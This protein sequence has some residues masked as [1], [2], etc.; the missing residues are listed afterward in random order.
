MDRT[1]ALKV[2][3]MVDELHRNQA[4]TPSE[5][6][7]QPRPAPPQKPTAPSSAQGRRF[8]AELGLGVLAALG[9]PPAGEPA[10]WGAA[11]TAGPVMLD[12]SL[13]LSARAEL[14][15]LPPVTAQRA[16]AQVRFGEIV[17][18]LVLHSQLR[19]GG[20][21]LG[22]HTGFGL[23]YVDATGTSSSGESRDATE[24]VALWLVGLELELPMGAGFGLLLGVELQARLRRQR[25]AVNGTEVVDLGRIRPLAGLALTWNP[26]DLR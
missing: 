15:W 1:L 9:G 16:G 21:W 6:M 26:A 4:R 14:S 12:G 18:A 22:A 10:R 5:A 3:E 23:S 20:L 19:Q 17:P 24:R 8:G 7:L 11:A 13:R 2:R 25:F